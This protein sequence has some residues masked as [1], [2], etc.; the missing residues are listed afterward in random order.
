M[1]RIRSTNISNKFPWIWSNKKS[2]RVIYFRFHSDARRWPSVFA[3]LL[4][5][6]S[7][8]ELVAWV[9][10]CW[11][12]T[13][14]I[15]FIF[16]LRFRSLCHRQSREAWLANF[17]IKHSCCSALVEGDKDFVLFVLCRSDEDINLDNLDGRSMKIFSL[18]FYSWFPI[19]AEKRTETLRLLA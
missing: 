5:A 6:S 1:S 7:L 16:K 9:S 13:R 8:F 11:K 4:T 19:S 12:W 10:C 2:P 3:S 17:I 15:L 14:W 18:L